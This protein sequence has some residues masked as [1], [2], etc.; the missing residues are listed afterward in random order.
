MGGRRAAG[1][2]TLVE[3][4]IALSILSIV[5]TI[6]FGTF[7]TSAVT[8]RAIDERADELSSLTGALDTLSHEVRSASGAFSGTNDKIIFTVLTPFHPDTKPWVQTV[9]YEFGQGKLLRKIV[10]PGL[11]VSDLRTFLLLDHVVDPSF[12]FFDGR[13]WKDEWPSPDKLP[14]GVRVTFSYKGKDINTV[15]PVWS[16]K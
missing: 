11:A 10:Q 6:L 7:S 1:G 16:R 5:M 9:A 8:A 3:I 15:M 4:L 14:A 2:F 13:Q 12:S